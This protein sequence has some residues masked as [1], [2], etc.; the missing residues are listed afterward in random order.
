MFK[1]PTV[2]LLMLAACGDNSHPG[3]HTDGGVDGAVL[4]AATDG[5]PDGPTP[6][7]SNAALEA[8]VSGDLVL[9]ATQA[10]NVAPLTVALDR[11]VLFVTVNE[12]EPSPAYGGVLCEL[13]A[14]DLAANTGAGVECS[15]N[16]AG[17][18]TGLGIINVRWTVATFSAGVSVQ[19][20][21]AQTYITN[22]SIIALSPAVDTA[23]SF[24]LLGGIVNGGT[25][26]G[27]NEFARAQLV[28]GS[29]L[30]ISTAVPGTSVAWQIV[31]V[32]GATVQRGTTAFAS[33]DTQH[34]VNVAASPRPL[35][36]ASYTTDNSS[37][38]AAAT[39]ML[40]A[41]SANTQLTLQRDLNGSGLNVSWELVTLPFVT[42]QAT[43]AFALTETTK[44]VTVANLPSASSVAIGTAQA[45]LGESSGATDYAG[46]D[47]DVPGEAA[48]TMS[49]TDN[50]VTLKRATG[51]SNANI[52]WTAIDFSHNECTPH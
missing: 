44:T 18:D 24:V 7:S 2:I 12:R 1:K 47:L 42:R 48:A 40:Q 38:I 23:K 36:L 29:T 33:A 19:R 26:W 39:V 21:E 35:L 34:V 4:D 28:D 49:V 37:G 43:T 8:L 6:C 45:V 22:P 20:G 15:R 16:N 50:N 11:S 51:E 5:I 25:G 46:A 17:T 27:N 14:A 31:T 13:K 3:Q 41:S 32:D 10:A 30:N 9:D 52:S